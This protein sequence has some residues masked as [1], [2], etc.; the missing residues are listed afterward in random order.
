MRERLASGWSSRDHQHEAVAAE[1]KR[2]QAA[3]IDGAGD[4]ADIGGAFRDQADDLVGQALLEVDADVGIGHQER[5][6]RLRQEFGERIGVGE[7][8]HLAG[9]PARIR[10]SSPP[11]S[12]RSAPGFRA[13]AAA[14]CG[15]PGVGATP[16]RP[17]TSNAVPN[18]SSILRMRVEAA[19]S[20]RLAR[21]APWVMLPASTMWRN[22]LRSVKSKRIEAAT[23]L[24][25]EGRLRKTH[26]ACT[27][28]RG[29]SFVIDEVTGFG[30]RSSLMASAGGRCQASAPRSHAFKPRRRALISIN[31]PLRR[32]P[33]VVTN[34]SRSSARSSGKS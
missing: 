32:W 2:V 29:S 6:Q 4:D 5:A 24:F 18:A 30:G 8:P 10:A 34:R 3:V 28:I 7:H 16:W 22:R 20:A 9:E 33:T 14:R 23:F 13:R 25:Y 17:R 11:A 12:A 15:R 21:A 26:I 27:N 31:G 19:A 1:R